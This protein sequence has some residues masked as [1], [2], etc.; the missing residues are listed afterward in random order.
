MVF[1]ARSAF[2]TILV[3]VLIYLLCFQATQSKWFIANLLKVA[4][5]SP[6]S[7]TKI[8]DITF[9]DHV[10][11]FPEFYQFT[12]LDM[13]ILDKKTR[14]RI[15]VKADEVNLSCTNC[16]TRKGMTAD[17][18]VNNLSL[19]KRNELSASGIFF[20][21]KARGESYRYWRGE[22][23]LRMDHVDLSGLVLKEFK[24]SILN[25]GP[26][27]QIRDLW[28]RASGGILK[29]EIFLES[30]ENLAYSMGMQFVDIDVD[31][32]GGNMRGLKANVHGIFDG[33]VELKGL[34]RRLNKIS[35]RFVATENGEVHSRL[36]GYLMSYLPGSAVAKELDGLIKANAFVPL[37]EFEMTF[38]NVTSSSLST[39]TK[40]YSSQYGLDANLD[41]NI[42]LGTDILNLM[43]LMKGK[44]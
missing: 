43:T 28:T 5:S 35:G 34:D 24:A 21:M 14:A 20:D 39:T 8:I 12:D 36:I 7:P 17:I 32:M 18:D 6:S 10:F 11:D 42:N 19:H 26:R 44:K 3:A 23:D 9:T 38:A 37:E 31:A 13:V 29:G 25:K 15:E 40:M 41:I 22:G 4:S 2:Y 1:P 27:W 16:I 30:T 33:F